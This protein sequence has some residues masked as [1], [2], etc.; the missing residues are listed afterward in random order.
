MSHSD[1]IDSVTVVPLGRSAS[2]GMLTSRLCPLD[3]AQ[4]KSLPDCD[5]HAC[6]LLALSPESNFAGSS[7]CL[8]G[9]FATY[10][11]EFCTRPSVPSVSV[12]GVPLG[13]SHEI[14][15]VSC[16]ESVQSLTVG[17]VPGFSTF[18]TTQPS[19]WRE[20]TSMF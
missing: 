15:S 12:Y 13:V 8:P 19:S 3:G 20:K 6:V 16:L 14:S 10:A 11:S 7:R 9:S 4:P 2:P 17:E 5:H 1:F 18:G